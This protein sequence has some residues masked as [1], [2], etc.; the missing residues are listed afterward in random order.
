MPSNWSVMREI[1]MKKTTI[2]V[3]HFA[4]TLPPPKKE[5]QIQGVALRIFEAQVNRLEPHFDK[6][7]SEDIPARAHHW[8]PRAAAT[9]P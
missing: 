8:V 6:Y 3:R 7:L 1:R 4:Q 5:G 9:S 2:R